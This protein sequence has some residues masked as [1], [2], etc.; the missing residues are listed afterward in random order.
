MSFENC[1][2]ELEQSN[3]AHPAR[4]KALL[5]LL[6]KR[7]TIHEERHPVHLSAAPSAS[8]G[9]RF[10]QLSKMGARRT[11]TAGILGAIATH[12]VCSGDVWLVQA[13]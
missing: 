5:R 4:T 7:V 3:A 2:A 9:G 1:L 13:S 8:M 10:V 11:R 12:A 6:V